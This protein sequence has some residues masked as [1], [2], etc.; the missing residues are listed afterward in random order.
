MFGV[1]LNDTDI[2][3]IYQHLIFEHTNL[4]ILTGEQIREGWLTHIKAEEEN[5]LWVSNLEVYINYEN[6]DLMLDG[7]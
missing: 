5:Y 6:Y 3:Y 7:L 2:E 4:Q 1:S